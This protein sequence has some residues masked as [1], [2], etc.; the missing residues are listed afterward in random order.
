MNTSRKKQQGAST[1]AVI[2][3]LACIGAVAYLGLQYIPQFIEANNVDAILENLETAHRESPFDSVNAVQQAIYRQLDINQM[4][5]L[6]ENFKVT[7][8][9]EAYLVTVKYERELDLVYEKKTLPHDKSVT[10]KRQ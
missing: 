3:V 2:L 4:E 1:V 5:D 7:D 9:D 10:L 8:V 6:R